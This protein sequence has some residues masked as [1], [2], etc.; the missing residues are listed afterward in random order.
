[1][2][3]FR[4]KLFTEFRSLEIELLELFGYFKKISMR[5]YREE[6]SEFH[7]VHRLRASF[8]HYVFKL[9]L[10]RLKEAE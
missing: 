6:D 5:A 8:R 10:S 3:Q 9:T 7:Y 2:L 4:I 1:M